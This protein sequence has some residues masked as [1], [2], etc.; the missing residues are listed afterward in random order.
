[1]KVYDEEHCQIFPVSWN[2]GERLCMRFCDDT[3][4]DIE[5][6]LKATAENVDVKLMLQALQLSLEFEGKLERRFSNNLKV[7]NLVLFMRY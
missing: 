5:T 2:M 7:S 4:K 3:R 6:V 1:M